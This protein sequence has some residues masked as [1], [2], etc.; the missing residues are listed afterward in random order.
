[1]RSVIM[2][3]ALV[4]ASLTLYAQESDLNEK[5]II[6]KQNADKIFSMNKGEWEKYVREIS[7]PQ[8][9]AI[10]LGYMESGTNIM[11]INKNEWYGLSVHPM[12]IDEKQPPDVLFVNSYYTLGTLPENIEELKQHVKQGVEADLGAS[13]SVEVVLEK[14]SEYVGVKLIII[15]TE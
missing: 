3:V 2:A 9:W 14:L 11:F 5:Q 13:Y 6:N 7:A 1:M 10:Q 4:L 12:F 15:K 8:G